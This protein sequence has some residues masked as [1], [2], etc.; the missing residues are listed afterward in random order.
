MTSRCRLGGERREKK[1]TH[2]IIKH[3]PGG[4][5]VKTSD[6]KIDLSNVKSKC[7]SLENAKHTPKRSEVK[8]LNKKMDLSHVKSK[9]GRRSM[10]NKEFTGTK[11]EVKIFNEKISWESIDSKVGSL[12]NWEYFD[13]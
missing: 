2:S 7:G 1:S 5:N 4:G 6:K 3:S 13:K 10:Q 11:S 12:E 9:D 8:I